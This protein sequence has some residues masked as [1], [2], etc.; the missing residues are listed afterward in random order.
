MRLARVLAPCLLIVLGGLGTSCSMFQSA[1]PKEYWEEYQLEHGPPRRDL[2]TECQWALRNAGYPPGERDEA[3]G[4]V[5]SGWLVSL[6][7]F[8]NRG[9]RYQG[10]ILAEPSG[11]VGS[12][13]LKVRVQVEANT[14]KR[15]TLEPA[16]AKWEPLDDDV[17]RAGVLMEHVLIQLRQERGDR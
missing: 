8:A 9:R 1:P 13:L 10:V 5:E 6:H 3:L 16:S 12:Y 4:Q 2:L 7:P 14:E 15:D 17:S 11:E